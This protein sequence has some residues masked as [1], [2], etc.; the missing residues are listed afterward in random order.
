MT[1]IRPWMTTSAPCLTLCANVR[2]IYALHR[3]VK[4]RHIAK[5]LANVC[6][7]LVHPLISICRH[8]WQ[9]VALLRL[10]NTSVLVVRRRRS[11]V[12]QLNFVDALQCTS[13][14]PIF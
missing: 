4:S 14:A 1:T 9:L 7:P 3:G 2:L 8:L 13:P 6:I 5:H 12:D 10:L 11:F